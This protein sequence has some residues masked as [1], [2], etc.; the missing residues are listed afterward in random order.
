MS[1]S[2]KDVEPL[3]A[4]Q[5]DANVI[6]P[7]VN[8]ND[9]V[10]QENDKTGDNSYDEPAKRVSESLETSS[11]KKGRQ[12][13]QVKEKEKKF[14]FIKPG[15]S[16]TLQQKEK[17]EVKVQARKKEKVVFLVIEKRFKIVPKG[18]EFKWNLPLSMADY[19]DLHFKN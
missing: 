14:S 4:H 12:T 7:L 6:S 17:K 1:K 15:D 3:H 2:L 13:T 9:E 11:T 19:A 18:E 8:S 10:G 16:K 5:Y